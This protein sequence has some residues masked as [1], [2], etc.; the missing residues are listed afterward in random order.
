MLAG[1]IHDIGNVA[2][3]NKVT[4]H[5][6]ILDNEKHLDKIIAKMHAQVGGAIL[7]L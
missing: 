4:D 2:I 1:L 7:R 6:H 5:P 3:L